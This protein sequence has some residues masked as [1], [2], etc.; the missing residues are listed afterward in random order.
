M[1]VDGDAVMV[2]MSSRA[3]LPLY[4][5]HGRV[6]SISFSPDGRL[7]TSRFV[8]I[9]FSYTYAVAIHTLSL[10]LLCCLVGI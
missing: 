7:V 5:F 4:K 3:S 2:N 10:V 6:H 8:D 1:Y 9:F